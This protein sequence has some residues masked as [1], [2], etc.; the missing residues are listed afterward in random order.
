MRVDK[1]S[2]CGGPVYPGHGV[3]FVRNDSKTFRF[4]R[5]KCH[6]HFKM[7]H[8]PRKTRWTKA[9]RRL[10]GRELTVDSTLD[11]EKKRNR[12]VKYDRDL[13][14][15]TVHALRRIQEIRQRRE[16]SFY[17]TR[18]TPLRQKALASR[19][20]QLAKVRALEAKPEEVERESVE[21]QQRE[22]V[23]AETVLESTIKLSAA[24]GAARK[25]TKKAEK[26][27]AE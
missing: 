17:L 9:Y 8:N 11:F 20:K 23:T 25:K 4:C 15:Q 13:W 1:C 27:D 22:A 3:M 14:M 19:L 16:R 5:S 24:R 7:K 2:F 10:T 18:M 26:M 21:E 12:P 6:R